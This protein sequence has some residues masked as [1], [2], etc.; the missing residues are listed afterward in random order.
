METF[1]A[2]LATGAGNTPVPGEFPAQRPV[3]RSFDVFFDLRPNKRLS[4]QWWGWWFQTPSSPLWRHCNGISYLHGGINWNSILQL[5]LNGLARMGGYQEHEQW[6]SVAYFTKEV[7]LSLPKYY[8]TQPACLY[9]PG[10]FNTWMV[11]H[12]IDAKP[13]HSLLP[14]TEQRIFNVMCRHMIYENLACNTL[15][16]IFDSYNADA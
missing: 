9:I 11:W 14:V 13:L 7:K 3:T 2:L 15:T 4:K 10:A 6:P 1:S 12:I 5:N 8:V 16:E